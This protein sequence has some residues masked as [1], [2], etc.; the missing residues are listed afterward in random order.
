MTWEAFLKYGLTVEGAAVVIGCVM[1][2]L[3]DLLPEFAQ[4]AAKVKRVAFL[5]FCLGLPLLLALLGVLTKV[6][7]NSFEQT[8][9]LALQAGFVAFT[10]GQLTHL[11]NLFNRT[12]TLNVGARLLVGVAQLES[13]MP[14]TS[15]S[16]T[17]RP[18]A[19]LNPWLDLVYR[20]LQRGSKTEA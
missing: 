18:L 17:R 19:E 14:D 2:L 1:S 10:S 16:L 20:A 4:L 6:L 3:L 9:W 15:R 5:L 12:E 13:S 11:R 7:P 8:Y